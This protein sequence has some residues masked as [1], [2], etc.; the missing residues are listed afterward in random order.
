MMQVENVQKWVNSLSVENGEDMHENNTAENGHLLQ[1]SSNHR[2]SDDMSLG[3]EA[4][5][6][7][8][9][10]DGR[11]ET[12]AGEFIQDSELNNNIV[13]AGTKFR[14]LSGA[15]TEGRDAAVKLLRQRFRIQQQDSFNSEASSHLTIDSIDQLLWERQGDPEQILENLG[16]VGKIVDRRHRIPE[17]FLKQSSKANGIS[18]DDYLEKNLWLKEYLDQKAALQKPF[19][20]ITENTND[21]AVE[22]TTEIE[23]VTNKKMNAFHQVASTVTM[24]NRFRTL[25]KRLNAREPEL[26]PLVEP[27]LRK[28]S[29][30]TKY[31]SIL[32]LDNYNFLDKMGYYERHVEKPAKASLY[33]FNAAASSIMRQVSGNSLATVSQETPAVNGL[34]DNKPHLKQSEK[35]DEIIHSRPAIPTEKE[36]ENVLKVLEK[37]EPPGLKDARF[38]VPERF[39]TSQSLLF[40]AVQPLTGEYVSELVRKVGDS[41]LNLPNASDLCFVPSGNVALTDLNANAIEDLSKISFDSLH[42]SVSSKSTESFDY[43]WQR[44]SVSSTGTDYSSYSDSDDRAIFFDSCDDNPRMEAL[45]LTIDD[46]GRGFLRIPS[47]VASNLSSHTLRELENLDHSSDQDALTDAPQLS[48]DS[49][50]LRDDVGIDPFNSSEEPDRQKNI[51]DISSQSGKKQDE[52]V[53]QLPPVINFSTKIRGVLRRQGSSQ[54]DSSGFVD[55]DHLDSSLLPES[56][57]PNKVR[58]MSRQMKLGTISSQDSNSMEEDS[59]FSSQSDFFHSPESVLSTSADQNSD[60]HSKNEIRILKGDYRNELWLTKHS[61][62]TQ[63][64]WNDFRNGTEE[65]LCSPYDFKADNKLLMKEKFLSQSEMYTTRLYIDSLPQR[66]TIPLIEKAEV[67]LILDGS[68][69]LCKSQVNYDDSQ[70]ESIYHVSSVDVNVLETKDGDQVLAPVLF[71]SGKTAK[72][73]NQ[74]FAEERRSFGHRRQ[75][76]ELNV[77]D[78]DDLESAVLLQE[79]ASDSSL[80]MNLRERKS[81]PLD[82]SDHQILHSLLRQSVFI[83]PQCAATLLPPS[84]WMA[85]G[86]AEISQKQHLL[87]EVKLLQHALQKYRLEVRVLQM[88]TKKLYVNERRCLLPGER[89]NLIAMEELHEAI[90]KE[91]DDLDTQLSQRMK[92]VIS[93]SPHELSLGIDLSCLSIIKQMT[94]LLKEQTYHGNI[95]NGMSMISP[96][97]RHSATG[98]A[99]YVRN[100]EEDLLLEKMTALEKKMEEQ[101][102]AFEKCLTN[103]LQQMQEIMQISGKS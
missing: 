9:T 94:E 102:T 62:E 93:V 92:L 95:I 59:T 98:M 20:A 39:L 70:M 43:E 84:Q 25:V 81:L 35:L 67:M 33:R 60:N 13:G 82:F 29:R 66:T 14:L 22:P 5:S 21:D 46:V 24:I 58:Y 50:S 47:D 76:T 36:N 15:C 74:M 89:D 97:S 23:N 26:E 56:Y 78:E 91:L 18:V 6:V 79:N 64:D 53:D 17:R 72:V 48:Q 37:V 52:A 88:Q 71:S 85:L 32:S 65:F 11:L 90:S 10:G 49:L 45:G 103:S 19:E 51:S 80:K 69:S 27:M 73:K 34:C 99:A 31:W 41:N 38:S 12:S 63:T 54:S 96:M 8:L 83:S 7:M 42:D 4:K 2:V 100:S 16:F 77:A 57:F 3:A 101:T 44:N 61:V 55:S 30:G 40:G 1:S 68:N 75:T 86:D 87:E 28:G